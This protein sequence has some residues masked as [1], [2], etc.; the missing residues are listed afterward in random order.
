M[1]ELDGLISAPQAA[2]LLGVNRATLYRYASTYDDFPE[3]TKIGRTVLY[4]PDALREWRR[5][6]PAIRKHAADSPPP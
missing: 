2:E 6:H 1:R 5:D 4:R 3:P